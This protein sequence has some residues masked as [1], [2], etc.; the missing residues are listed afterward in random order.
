MEIIVYRLLKGIHIDSAFDGEGARRFGGRWNSK[1]VP[2]VYTSESL[3]LCSL[4]ILVHLPSYDL[5][6]EYSYIRV[7]FDANL[8]IDAQ[9]KDGWNDRPVSK[10]S[11]SIGDQWVKEM[12]SPVLKVPSVIM[13][14]GNNYLI[15]I[16]HP[17]FSKMKIDKPLSLDFDP[18]LRK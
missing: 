9:V 7:V 15:N 16:N 3:A 13:P 6:K 14:D 8:V 2:M 17:D 18:R 11:Q 12:Q 4:E 5:L 1:G 10:I